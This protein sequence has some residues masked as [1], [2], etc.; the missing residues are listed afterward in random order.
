MHY[1]NRILSS[2][3]IAFSLAVST[4]ALQSGTKPAGTGSLAGRVLID[5]KPQANVT[6]VL[7]QGRRRMTTLIPEM[8]TTTDSEGNFKIEKVPANDYLLN[9][10]TPG[11]V[12]PA[13]LGSILPEKGRPVVINAGE[14]LTGIEI[15]LKRGAVITGR[16]VDGNHQP[17]IE[18]W[19]QLYKLDE[20]G[21]AQYF[22]INNP[23]MLLTDDRGEYRLYG[24]PAGRYKIGLGAKPG[25]TAAT[26]YGV[27]LYQLT[28][29]PDTTDVMKAEIIE[30]GDGEEAT[31]I[32]I[33]LSH[34]LKTYTASGRI[35]DA[36]TGKP[37]ANVQYFCGLVR[38][39]GEYGGMVSPAMNPTG[40]GEM[41]FEGLTPGRY[42]AM[43]LNTNDSETYAEAAPF[44]IKDEDV[45]GLELKIYRGASISGA[46]VV[47]GTDDPQILALAQQA[48]IW[49]RTKNTD[50]TPSI[51]HP[52][53]I[54]ADGSFKLIGLRPG[55]I[56]IGADSPFNNKRIAYVRTEHNGV[57]V[58]EFDVKAGEQITG[59]R[60]VMV[61]ATGVIRGTVKVENGSLAEN[62]R[63]WAM[64]RRAGETK[65]RSMTEVDAR[66]RFVIEGLVAGEYEILLYGDNG[67]K[68]LP[69]G[70]KQTVTVTNDAETPVTLV[71]NLEA[72]NQD[73]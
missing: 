55:K 9:A 27:N 35:I 41:F 3:L 72:K 16:V 57:E 71:I 63:L 17:L 19:L 49:Q 5:G 36:A 44:D 54:A 50:P 48:R 38:P 29:H 25:M 61:Y 58:K 21:E 1:L 42:A 20:K 39:T 70:I 53:P 51:W 24:L 32:D 2:L 28:Y 62:A 43:I 7:Q 12:N 68:P 10:L 52:R 67:N 31:N 59:I 22:Y 30:L 11:F 64:I 56:E 33:K 45:Q 23:R 65:T 4:H 37:V 6:V 18:A 26:R 46:V 15:A 13:E 14:E 8:K 47:E 60:I 34:K 40:R 66:G 73:K 69:R